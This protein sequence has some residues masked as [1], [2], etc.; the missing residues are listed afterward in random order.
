M[1]Q[2][3]G[4][5]DLIFDGGSACFGADGTV[6]AQAKLLVTGDTGPMHFA[7]AL[8][9][10]TLS[11]FGPT[12]ARR[13]AP[14]GRQ[15]RSIQGGL[16]SCSGHSAVCTASSSC[17]AQITPDQVYAEYERMMSEAAGVASMAAA[18][19]LR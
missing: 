6:L 11:L 2:V 7:A 3:G 14:L 17:L 8:G 1:N 12:S 16:C 13:W 5:D 19:R 15:H 10:P 4:N 9:V 18:Q